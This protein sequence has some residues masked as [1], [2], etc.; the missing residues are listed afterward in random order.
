MH[1]ARLH[2]STTTGGNHAALLVGKEAGPPSHL[3]LPWRLLVVHSHG[4]KV[5]VLQ[6]YLSLLPGLVAE[7]YSS[8]A[9]SP[10]PPFSP[11][12]KTPC[13]FCH[14][15]FPGGLRCSHILLVYALTEHLTLAMAVV[16][17]SFIYLFFS[18]PSRL[19]RP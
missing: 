11:S 2:S 4:I 12:W 17:Y 10:R 7:L 19:H 5:G 1:T 6:F 14:S 8:S 13:C 16:L 15:R 3:N 9:S 18:P